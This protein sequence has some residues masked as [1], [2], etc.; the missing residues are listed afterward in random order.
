M[1]SGTT[2]I[3]KGSSKI[4]ENLL[5]EAMNRNWKGFLALEDLAKTCR[6]DR[7]GKPKVI[8]LNRN[9]CVDRQ[10][11]N[12]VSTNGLREAL[13]DWFGIYFGFTSPGIDILIVGLN[14][15]IFKKGMEKA[16]QI[17]APERKSPKGHLSEAIA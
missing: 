1:R 3:S 4:K 8:I 13:K 2:R 15:E 16:G 12:L 14:M 6:K 10:I 7:N 17:V 11:T 5:K 9:S